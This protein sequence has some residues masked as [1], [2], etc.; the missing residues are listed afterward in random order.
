M[1]R[2]NTGISKGIDSLMI[3]LYLLLV[4]IGILAIF[5]ATYRDDD[6]VLSSFF[7]FKNDYSK[8]FYFFVL[9]I[10][11]GV[12]ILLT[13]SKFFTA[14]ANISYAVFCLF[15]YHILSISFLFLCSLLSLVY[16]F[17]LPTVNFLPLPLTSGMLSEF[18]FYCWFSLLIP[19]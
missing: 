8:Q 19:M 6:P 18:C 13:D 11:I 10:V 14:T 15:L 9:S 7:S 1:S 4:G 5:G 17:C 12:F 16:S 3:W 2:N